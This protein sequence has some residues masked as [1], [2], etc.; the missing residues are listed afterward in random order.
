MS[1]QTPKFHLDILRI[2][3]KIVDEVL[4]ASKIEYFIEGGT[5]LGCVRD[6]DII[7]WDD[8][9]DIGVMTYDWAKMI[10]VLSRLNNTEPFEYEDKKYYIN[11]IQKD[12]DLCKV[13]IPT[14]TTKTEEGKVVGTPTLDIF[15]YEKHK[16]EI[17]LPNLNYRREFKNATYKIS[18]MYPIKRMKLGDIM[19]NTPN[20]P[21]GFITRYYGEDWMVPKIDIRGNDIKTKTRNVVMDKA[22]DKAES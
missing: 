17:R 10:N 7:P 22:Q 20:D 15:K 2:M 3:M 5:L 13:Y 11:F 9:I 14:F 18:E 21:I 8:D 1:M 19:V 16:K 4:I 12:N 6:G